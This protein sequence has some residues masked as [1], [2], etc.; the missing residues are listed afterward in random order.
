[1]SRG[2][3]VHERE[4]FERHYAGVAALDYRPLLATVV[5]Y[6][7]P[8]RVLD[9]GAGLGFLVECA[10]AFGVPCTGVEASRYAVEASGARGVELVQHDLG[11]PLPFDDATFAAVVLNQVVEH[12]EPQTALLTLEEAF[13]VLVPGGAVFVFTPTAYRFAPRREETHVNLYSPRRLRDAL[14]AAGFADVRSLAFGASGAGLRLGMLSYFPVLEALPT[15]ASCF[16]RK[17]G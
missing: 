3:R 12:L 5:R 17:S 6:A 4:D 15:S 2:G 1:V 13:R 8:G 16:A 14:C 10:R 7:P 9:L 11:R